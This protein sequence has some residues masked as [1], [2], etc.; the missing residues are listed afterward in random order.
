MLQLYMKIAIQISGQPR[1]NM[2]FNTMLDTLEGHDV[3][4]Y[5]HLWS[6]D[7][8]AH[9]D[10]IS[11]TWPTTDQAV[12]DKLEANLTSNCKIAGLKIV[13]QVDYTPPDK[14]NLTP[15]S[16]PV[17]IWYTYYGIKQANQMRVDANTD[18]DLVI[19][20][21]PDAGLASMLDYD[22]ILDYLKGDPL[23]VVTPNDRRFGMA[24]QAINDLIAIGLPDTITTYCSA[25]DYFKQY[26]DQGCP[27][28][29]E[30]LLAWHLRANK[31]EFPETSFNCTFREYWYKHNRIDFG[32]WA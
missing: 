31:I 24:G 29:G 19:K 15:W 26:N 4:F 8:T 22:F 30:S 25:V 6:M 2:D 18:Y 1:F 10:L 21:R 9:A 32:V 20:A 17:N 7:S 14:L 23:T 3:D 27:Y 11:P 28:H 5:F 13:P 16:N 12:R